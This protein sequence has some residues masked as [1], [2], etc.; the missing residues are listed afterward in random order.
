MKSP[1]MRN[2]MRGAGSTIAESCPPGRATS[3]P[4]V[5]SCRAIEANRAAGCDNLSMSSNEHQIRL[6]N[7][8]TPPPDPQT[9]VPKKH[10]SKRAKHKKHKTNQF[11]NVRIG[12]INVQTAKD[13]I[14]LAEYV[15]QVKALKHDIC[16]FQET[17]K[18]GFGEVE[19]DDP[20]LK[21][22]RVLYTGFKRKAQAGAA[23]VLAPHVILDDIMEI[24]S[25]RIIG[26]RIRIRGLKL[27]VFSCYAPTDTK[28]YSDQIKNSFYHTLRKAV[29]SVKKD[30]PSYKLVIGGDFNATIGT[31]FQSENSKCIGR[32][33]DPNPTSE[34]G[35]RLLQFANENKLSIMNTLFGHKNI[36]RWSFYSN[37]GYDRRLDYI[38]G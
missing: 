34:N 2:H 28:S 13:E 12:T 19:F 20:L 26:A 14:K 33:N 27:S 17:H 4:A 10:P 24:E 5:R 38:L 23:I 1:H 8:V 6:S 35:N 25:G 15:I 29:S 22:W 3:F 30:H 16:F 21:G 36:H 18:I 9:N 7:S 37:L 11:H 32:N 31:D